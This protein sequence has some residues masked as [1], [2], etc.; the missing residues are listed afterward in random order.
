MS[1][2]IIAKLVP[3]A[4]SIVVKSTSD[5]GLQPASTA[6]TLR[7]VQA[8]TNVAA[9]TANNT[10]Y[11]GNVSA[12][13]VVSNTQLQ[14]NLANYQTTAGLS[15]NVITLTANNTTYVGNTLAINVVSNTQLQSNLVNYAALAG[16]A[17]SGVVNATAFNAT[18]AANSSF[19]NNVSIAGQLTVLSDVAISGNLVVTGDATYVQGNNVIYTD[20]LLELHAPPGGIG[21]TWNVSD[22]VDIGL[23][24]HYYSGGDKN[25]ALVLAQDTGYLEWYSNGTE[26]SGVFSGAYGN[27]KANTFIATSPIAITSG[28]TGA[29]T[30]TAAQANLLGYTTT[31]S[32]GLAV[33]GASGAGGTATLTFATQASTPYAVNS[34][35]AVAGITPTGYAGVYQVTASNTTSV[36]YLNATTGAQTVAGNVTTAQP[37]TNTSSFYQVMTG[38]TFGAF[39]LPDTSTLQR[40]WSFRINNA[41]TTTLNL[42]TSTGVS[43][44]S[45]PGGATGYVTCIDTT[46]NTA[47]AWRFGVTESS[48]YTGTGGIVFN[49]GPTIVGQLNF[50]GS[51]TSAANFGTNQTTAA[52]VIG[53]ATQTGLMTIGRSTASQ[54]IQIG[55]SATT[56]ATTASGTSSTIATTV[57]TVGGTVTG[58]FSIGMALSGTG[59][60]PGTYITSL[61]TG[62]GAAGTYNINQ[63]QTVASATTITGTTQKS[64]DIG[65][66]GLSGSITFITLGSAT[67]GAISS[68]NINGTL[69]TGLN[70]ANYQQFTGAATTFTPIHSVVGSDTNIS[71]ALQSKGTGAIDLAAGSSGVNISNGGTVTSVVRKDSG[72]AYTTAPTWTASAPTTAGGVTATGT[73]RLII[74]A[75]TVAAGGTGYTVGDTLTLVGGTVATTA[76]TYTVATVSSGVVTSVSYATYGAYS[77]IPTSP[78][79]TTGGTGTGC[80]LNLTGVGIDS[81][82]TIANAGSG[83]VEQPT[84]TFSAGNALAYA[85]VGTNTN[86]RSLGNS[87][88][89]NVP[90]GPGLVVSGS[91]SNGG[92]Y[93]QAFAG[94]TVPILR[95]VG[96]TAGQIQTGSAVPLQF[97]TN[98]QGTGAEQFRV[99]HTASAVNFLVTTG[100]ATNTAVPLLVQGT[101]A[102]IPLYLYSKGTASI[103][104]VTNNTRQFDVYGPASAVNYIRAGGNITGSAPSVSSQGTDTN[105]DLTLTPKGTGKVLVS[106]NNGLGFANATGNSVAYTYYNAGSNSIDTV[107]G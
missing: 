38:T 78:A 74:Y 21:N 70:N 20:N 67:S 107:F 27:V 6:V 49:S 24:M 72:S 42:Y 34:Y 73:T 47:A 92:A 84:I 45:L 106:F 91:S 80:T 85:V 52:M 7:N 63:T 75:V 65:T 3:S 2:N 8:T 97:I 54:P 29:N 55:S 103:G 105:I 12:A 94:S 11:V 44:I 81:V 93:W 40:G 104:F 82:L 17:F 99:A 10:N 62:T 101:D 41:I 5:G 76:A 86:I 37:L 19:A 79:A 31:A 51:T 39:T 66:G 30:S 77:A 58:T 25:A 23:R 71:M 48:T 61:G 56:T 90:D 96:T 53:G 46:L 89:F 28:G 18:G 14:S 1:D 64:I 87:L 15:A 36:S 33:T 9:L 98:T 16:A 60:L 22:G 95:A 100:S 88:V 13:N 83:Y 57:L 4:A 102:N 50:T 26:T 43:L 69:N 35:I 32:N 59:V 68:V